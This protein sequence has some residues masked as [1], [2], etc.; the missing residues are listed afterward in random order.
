MGW[1][2]KIHRVQNLPSKQRQRDQGFKRGSG[3]I[4]LEKPRNDEIAAAKES[5]KARLRE[6][7]EGCSNMEEK[8]C[9]LYLIE[10]RSN[11]FLPAGT[12]WT[13][14]KRPLLCLHCRLRALNW[15]YKPFL[16]YFDAISFFLQASE[17]RLKRTLSKLKARVLHPVKLQ[18]WDCVLSSEL[19]RVQAYG[20][21]RCYEF[22]TW[23]RLALCLCFLSYSGTPPS[24]LLLRLH[25]FPRIPFRSSPGRTILVV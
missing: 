4:A 8:I 25:L 11:F 13:F 15:V 12:L 23:S 6:L 1:G 7:E 3:K 22:E 14:F 17:T 2:E 9:S 5:I 16:H 24:P 21:K 10:D 19:C 18:N 20:I